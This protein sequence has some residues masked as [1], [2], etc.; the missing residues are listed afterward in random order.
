MNALGQKLVQL[1]MPGVPDVYQ[2]TEV[3]EDS[4]VDPDNRR[5][6]D[7]AALRDL[8]AQVDRRRSPGRRARARPSSG[9]P[10]QALRARRD[11]PELFTGYA[12]VFADGPQA[13]APGRLRPRRC[14][15]PGHPAA[16]AAWPGRR[17]GRHHRRP[18]RRVH[19]RPDRDRVRGPD[20]VADLLGTYPVAL[21]IRG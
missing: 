9:S 1:T 8:L 21:L 3:W 18:A 19:R 17:L 13:D 14:D 2:G 7:F 12:P 4:L 10:P 20:R 15:H 5:P 16:G 11:R 6:V